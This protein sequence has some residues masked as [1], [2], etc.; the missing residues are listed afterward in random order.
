MNKSSRHSD[1]IQG[2]LFKTEPV[3]LKSR[4]VERAKKQRFGSMKFLSHIPDIKVRSKRLRR[5]AR[6]EM[7]VI[8]I[9]P[10]PKNCSMFNDQE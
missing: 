10:E 8:E 2:I 9:K 1:P 5:H 7:P 4:A 3:L 6:S